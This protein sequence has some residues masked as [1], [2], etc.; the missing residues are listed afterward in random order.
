MK[1]GFCLMM[2]VL[3]L[4]I[5]SLP[6]LGEE[7]IIRVTGNAAVSLS[8]DTATIQ[9]GVNTKKATVQEAQAENAKLMNAV[10][11][12]IRQAGVDEKDVTTSQFDVFS[13]FEYSYDD[14]GKEISTPCYQVSN[15][16]SVTIRDL[17]VLGAVLDVAVAAGANTTYGINFSSSRENEVYQKALVRAVEDAAN[18][19]KTLAS[20][21]GKE[22]GDLKL[23]DASQQNNFYGI[24]NTFNAKG[25]ADAAAIVSGDVS[26]SASVVLEY[27]FK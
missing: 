27:A 11:Q 22:L 9:I 13:S 19:A 3:M 17:S 1:K 23:I 25:A 12:A 20:A 16:L 5:G 14:Q 7:N 4:C 6:A 8:A 2:A 26:V 18:K 24:T 10:I 21:A 15:M